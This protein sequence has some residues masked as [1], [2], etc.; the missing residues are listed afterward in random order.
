MDGV[1]RRS[2]SSRSARV[3]RLVLSAPCVSLHSSKPPLEALLRSVV[4]QA[5]YA[6]E[7]ESSDPGQADGG[8]AAA[9]VG[10]SVGHDGSDR[11]V[12]VGAGCAQ[13]RARPGGS[14]G[15]LTARTVVFTQPEP[16]RRKVSGASSGRG[17]G[18]REGLAAEQAMGAAVDRDRDGA[19]SDCHPAGL[20]GLELFARNL[21]SH[22]C[23][24]GDQVLMKHSEQLWFEHRD[25]T[26]STSRQ[27]GHAQ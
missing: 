16:K 11:S 15:A 14:D 27:H 12:L 21:R 22:W 10:V 6:C 4:A 17:E 13:S 2:S 8:D 23:S 26:L 7:P 1:M 9:A 3:C 19:D 24:F 25:Q 5:D 20:V 18:E